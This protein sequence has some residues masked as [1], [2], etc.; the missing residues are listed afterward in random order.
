MLLNPI[1]YVPKT[2]DQY[3]L[4]IYFSIIAILAI[5]FITS[6]PLSLKYNS[7]RDIIGK[8]LV[9]VGIAELLPF[10]FGIFAI[11]NQMSLSYLL[12]NPLIVLLVL[13]L[14]TMAGGTLNIRKAEAHWFYLLIVS[15]TS[16]VISAFIVYFII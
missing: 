3:T 14:I 9:A 7:H 1:S 13:G 12:L 11:L 4:Q 5:T 6:T 16:I 2:L 15:L 10:F 8:I